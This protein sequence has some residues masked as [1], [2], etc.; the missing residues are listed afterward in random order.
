LKGRTLNKQYWNDLEQERKKATFIE[1]EEDPKLINFLQKESNLQICFEDALQCASGLGCVGGRILEI[2]AG[3]AW[4]SAILSRIPKVME[5]HA[6]DFSEHRLLKIA[7]IV[8]RQFKGDLSKFHPIVDDFLH[9][10]FE[11]SEK[12]EM[13][14]FCQSLYMFPKLHIVLEKVNQLLH[15]G[16][17]VII[18]CE[19]ITPTFPRTTLS[20]W[21]RKISTCFS[22]RADISGNN[23]YTDYEYKEA[24]QK[25]GF[26]YHFQNLFYPVYQG[27]SINAGNHFGIKG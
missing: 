6:I 8:F 9:M 22:G 7:P 21:R 18:A 20:Y 25:A 26:I 11:E 14:L 4:T 1:N 24:L 3:V 2:G 12:F 17:C 16:G 27:A 23:F 13:V 19:R 15:T 5:I 10:K